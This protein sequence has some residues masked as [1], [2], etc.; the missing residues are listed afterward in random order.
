MNKLIMTTL[1][2]LRIPVFFIEQ[3]EQNT[4]PQIVFNIKDTPWG[5]SDDEQDGCQYEIN[6]SLLVKGDYLR[7]KKE[8][9]RLMVNAEF[10]KGRGY[11]PEYSA[12]LECYIVPL[13]FYYYKLDK[14][15]MI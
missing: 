6:M 9:E 2:P 8:I 3:G 7:L 4:Y 15:E 1:S 5:F 11:Y 10:K 13:R 14:G 12:Q